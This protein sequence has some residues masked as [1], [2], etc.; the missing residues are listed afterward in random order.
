MGQLAGPV[1]PPPPAGVDAA[2]R[3]ALWA[4]LAERGEAVRELAPAPVLK[5]Q[6]K[7]PAPLPTQEVA[8]SR[9]SPREE[10]RRDWGPAG[11][12]AGEDRR[13]GR[14]AGRGGVGGA[15]GGEPLRLLH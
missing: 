15:A 5:Q 13:E 1:A 10:G 7:P 9:W 12:A 4:K 3:Q 14:R 8:P 2:G 11:R 6:Q